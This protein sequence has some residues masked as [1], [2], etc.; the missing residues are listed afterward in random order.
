AR[1]PAV[2]QSSFYNQ[3]PQSALPLYQVRAVSNGASINSYNNAING[4]I[5]PQ[6]MG[7]SGGTNFGNGTPYSAGGTNYVLPYG[8]FGSNSPTASAGPSL[9]TPLPGFPVYNNGQSSNVGQVSP[10]F[11]LRQVRVQQ[12]SPN[13]VN[14]QILSGQSGANTNNPGT[15]TY[16]YS[17]SA[18]VNGKVNGQSNNLTAQTNNGPQGIGQPIVG[19]VGAPKTKQAVPSGDLYQ[20]LIHE[21]ASGEKISNTG[22]GLQGK[23][24]ITQTTLNPQE[25]QN[26]N[27]LQIDPITGLPIAPLTAQRQV[28]ST[29]QNYNTGASSNS[30]PNNVSNNNNTG[31]NTNM[32][33]GEN[34]SGMG[35]Q[36]G[37]SLP[38]GLSNQLQSGQNVQPLNTLVGPA[39]GDFNGFMKSAQDNMGKGLFLYAIQDYQAAQ[40]LD[41]NNMLPI[42]GQANAELGGG[43]YT[44]AINDFKNIFTSHPEL[45]AVRY[46]LRAMLPDGSINAVTTDL[47]PMTEQKSAIAAFLLS[48]VYYQTDQTQKL[49]YMLNTWAKWNAADPWPGILH[50]AWLEKSPSDSTSGAGSGTA[51]P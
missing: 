20:Q 32:N 8:Y 49:Q 48:Y 39:P 16:L 9:A 30:T 28:G 10:L 22:S 25:E 35:Q 19:M 1:I 6:G 12:T 50:K 17:N 26:Q 40:S 38:P 14:G 27:V 37:V 45:T 47:L 11:G 36:T 44:S 29:P 24:A 18:Q 7:I 5:N 15:G 42:V 13:S 3:V 33:T 34:T 2:N 31:G 51:N 41:S 4:Q 23:P 46:N 21:L 43:F